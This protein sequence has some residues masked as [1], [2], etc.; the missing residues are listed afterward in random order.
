MR[1]QAVVW[2][3]GGVLVRTENIRPREK[4]A[5]SLQTSLEELT[6]FMF[7]SPNASKTMRGEIPAANH[8]QELGLK[9]GMDGDQLH[10]SFFSGDE[11]D[12]ELIS[13]I[14]GLRPD[15][16]TAL[17]SNAF[18][19]L[20]NHLVHVRK[21]ADVFDEILISAEEKMVKP[22]E[23]IYKLMLSRL[24]VQ[25]EET[26]FIDDFVENVDAAGRIG[27]NAILFESREQTLSDLSETLDR[28][29]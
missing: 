3:Y 9:F 7:N 11:L 21:I 8:W 18:D 26:I 13:F 22:D 12:K 17:L 5:Q 6:Y 1:I 24:R 27:M 23:E 10:D 2:D 25:A 19:T 28:K 15:F 4:L 14:R 16:K 20:R 29:S